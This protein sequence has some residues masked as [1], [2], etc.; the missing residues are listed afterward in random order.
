MNVEEVKTESRIKRLT[1]ACCGEL[2]LGRQWYNRDTGY[3]ACLKCV[4]WSKSRGE[5]DEEIKEYYGIRG[6][7]YGVEL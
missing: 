7:H 6:I 5:S 4:E 3:G 2:A 1:C